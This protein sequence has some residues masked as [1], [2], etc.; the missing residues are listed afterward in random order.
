VAEQGK[1]HSSKLLNT[2]R[3]KNWKGGA[4]GK[5]VGSFQK[6]KAQSRRKKAGLKKTVGEWPGRDSQSQSGMGGKG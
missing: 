6:D 3:E 5:L 4:R 2:G 1:I